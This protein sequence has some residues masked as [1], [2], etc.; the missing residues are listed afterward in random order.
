MP[1]V[2]DIS[3][4]PLSP[5][6]RQPTRQEELLRIAYRLMADKGMHR[7]TLQD[8]ADAAGMSKANVVYHYKTKEN[9]VLATM[10]WV[11]QRVAAR[12][13]QATASAEGRNARIR[14][15]IDAIF[16]DPQ[17]NRAFYIVYAEL[18]THSS[19]NGRFA[20]LNGWFREIVTGQ[21]A[22]IIDGTSGRSKKSVAESAMVVRALI[23]GLFLQWLE[24]PDWEA[25]H[26]Q[27]KDLCARSIIAFLGE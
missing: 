1:G 5:E 4:V 2:D 19:R 22:T 9:L 15:M 6:Q 13:V 10:E 21:Y 3:P 14:A 7:M 26:K 20:E 8:V 16:V 18:I 11:L 27:Y 25:R 17:R 24:E 23:D 12:V